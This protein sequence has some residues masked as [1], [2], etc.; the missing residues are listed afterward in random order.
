MSADGS[1]RAAPHELQ[2]LLLDIDLDVETI[3]EI[4]GLLELKRNGREIGNGARIAVLDD[5]IETEFALA[6]EASPTLDRRDLH[7]EATQL[8]REI[9]KGDIGV[10]HENHDP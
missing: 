8:F 7:A 1:Q 6:R 5:L 4:A 2:E 10:D 9:V 3:A